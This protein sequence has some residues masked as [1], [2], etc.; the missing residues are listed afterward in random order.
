MQ[1]FPSKTAEALSCAVEAQAEVL[2]AQGTEIVI[3]KSM[4][5]KLPF[6]LSP[7]VQV[8]ENIAANPGR[9]AD[10]SVLGAVVVLTDGGENC[11]EAQADGIV[12]RIGTAAETLLGKG[13]KSYAVR[14]GSEAGRTP[15]AEEQLSALVT[16]GGTA[17]VDPMNPS[18]KPYVDA[19]TP[20]RMESAPSVG[21]ID[22]SCR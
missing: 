4:L 17:I 8:I 21:P 10:P 11:A 14:Y 18:A 9:L 5:E 3:M 16:K 22:C 19:T 12:T 13:V 1:F 2:P 20:E 15:E 7:V 6:G